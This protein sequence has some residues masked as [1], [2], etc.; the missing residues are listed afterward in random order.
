MDHSIDALSIVW[1]PNKPNE[2]AREGFECEHEPRI[3]WSNLIVAVRLL[4]IQIRFNTLALPA[5]SVSSRLRP[6]TKLKSLA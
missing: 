1:G 4:A 2:A 3:A 5:L 6:T